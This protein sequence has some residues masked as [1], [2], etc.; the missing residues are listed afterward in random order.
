MQRRRKRYGLS[1]GGLARG[2]GR[3]APVSFA[4]VRTRRHGNARL[5]TKHG[6]VINI[7]TP[8]RDDKENANVVGASAGTFI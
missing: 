6:N 1:D 4:A 7:R 5:Q 8:R 2:L 3:N